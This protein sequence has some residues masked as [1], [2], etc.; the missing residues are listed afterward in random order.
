MGVVGPV[1]AVGRA[2]GAGELGRRGA[3]DDVDLLLFLGQALHGEGDR[4]GGELHDR[5]DLLGVVPLAG[6]VRGDVGLVLVVGGDDLDRRAEHRAAVV[7]GGHLRGLVGPLAAE[8]GVDAGL[9]VEDADLDLAVRD[10]LRARR[11]ARPRPRARREV[12]GVSRSSLPAILFEATLLG[13]GGLRA[14]GGPST[15][16][17]RGRRRPRPM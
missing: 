8:V 3:G 6:D 9:V 11:E 13:R 10:F 1:E 4:G 12:R 17:P 2:L 15:L 7:L 16:K 5:V 14:R